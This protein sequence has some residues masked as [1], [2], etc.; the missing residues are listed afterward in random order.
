MNKAL[1]ITT[2][3]LVL[4]FIAYFA[5]NQ[6]VSNQASAEVERLAGPKLQELG[7]QYSDL[8]VNPAGGSLT[9]RNV[10][11]EEAYAEELTVGAS[12]Q[13]LL[14]LMAGSS[15][16]LHGLEV[17][18]KNLRLSDK[19]GREGL[20]IGR[21]HM[22]VDALLDLAKLQQDPDL[23]FEDLR[24]QENV[25]VVLEGN[26]WLIRSDEI[27]D[28]LEMPTN[29]LRLSE[30]SL[31]VDKKGVLYHVQAAARESNLGRMEAEA[32]GSEHLLTYFRGSLSDIDFGNEDFQIKLSRGDMELDA[33]LPLSNVNDLDDMSDEWLG[34]L[35]KRGQPFGWS[36]S[37]S[38]L[39]MG[40]PDFVAAARELGLS[41]GQITMSSLKHDA[42]FSNNALKA[43]LNLRSNAGDA[44]ANIDMRIAN[45]AQ[46][47]DPESVQFNAL[48]LELTNLLPMAADQLRAMPS[49]LEPK[50]PNGFAF[51]YRGSA[52]G[53][54]ELGL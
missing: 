33:P 44:K 49:P 31:D 16:F 29:T 27:E 30:W 43:S 5:T 51:S 47:D 15:M 26:D 21:G 24:S 6:V 18:V 41:G 36:I 3:V 53:L 10:Q 46:L 54:G 38:N 4:A 39:Q 34:D 40:S 37:L 22:D 1:T 14:D 48:S 20:E 17:D 45:L 50:G 32:K 8:R 9:L 23:F 35:I 19:R 7:V 28:D 52:A 13:D 42:S 12:H 2:A 25:H 11:L